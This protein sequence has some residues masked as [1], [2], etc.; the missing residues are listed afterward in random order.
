MSTLEVELVAP[1]RAVGRPREPVPQQA[2]ELIL[3]L[4]HEGMPITDIIA[5]GLPGVPTSAMGIWKWKQKDEEFRVAYDEARAAGAEVV[6]EEA[7]RILDNATPETALV[8][9]L[10]AEHRYKRA[11]CFCPRVFGQKSQVEH[12]GG[13]SIVL[14]TGIRRQQ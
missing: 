7:G 6:F 10:R 4:L 9:K 11:A 5:I 14:D 2:A 13:V 8:A 12:S 3:D 1:S